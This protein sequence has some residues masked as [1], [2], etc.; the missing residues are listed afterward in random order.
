[1][2][3][4][5]RNL[6]KGLAAG[7][8]AGALGLSAR[9]GRGD[10]TDQ[11][12][13]FL[14]VIGCFG[15]A[16]IIDA[17]LA[18]KRSESR[19]ADTIN[20]FED[21]LVQQFEGS[22]LRA[23]DLQRA[24]MG[25]IPQAFASLQ[26]DFVKKHRHEMMVST[27]TR[28]SVNHFVGQSR[29]VTGNDAWLGRTLQEVV[30]N[31]YGASYALPNVHLV[32]GVGFTVRGR[33]RTLPTWA[34]GEQVADPT[35]W[36]ISLDG[37]R[38][39]RGAPD[40]A[41]V[42]RARG[43]RDRLEA[44]SRF[45][46]IFAGSERLQHWQ[47]LRGD[48]VRAI[49]AQN[50]VDKL[51]LV[52]DNANYPLSE[53]GLATSPD[54]ARLMEAFPN[55]LSDPL[56]AQA[57]MAFLLIKNRLSVTVTLG[58]SSNVA[59]AEGVDINYGGS[60]GLPPG[61]I[62]N[63][64]ISFD[65][66]HQAHRSVQA[67]MWNRVYRIADTLIGLLK[68][69]EWDAGQSLWDRTLIYCAS[70]FGRT[71]SRPAGADEFGTGHHLNNGVLCI[72]PFVNGD[73][74]LGGVDPDTALTYGFDPDSGAPDPGREMEEREIFAGLVHA[75]GVDTTDSELPDMRAMRRQA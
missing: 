15:G 25:P 22:P 54:A 73:K 67:F 51:L 72:S 2:G 45:T 40:K 65:F 30:A 50:L 70:D 19:N 71:R 33:D 47:H 26:S 27:W 53:F 3:I 20:C 24:E 75:L 29:A 48:P 18:I 14:I 28:T 8:A 7:A 5:R 41:L 11:A 55:L 49:E 62:M 23:V 36:P 1:M 38:G 12:P 35:S 13:R 63:P 46:R 6:L 52:P 60:D 68:E 74:V 61:S 56:E 58:P 44:K 32:G 17:T 4:S 69:E 10:T 64:P 16:S 21:A 9:R 42:E 34:F 37:Q 43:L 31:E 66:S 59:I 57:A 39:I